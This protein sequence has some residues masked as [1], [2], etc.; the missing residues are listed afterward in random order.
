[1]KRTPLNAVG[2]AARLAA[3]AFLLAAPTALAAA[4]ASNPGSSA[5]PAPVPV[6]DVSVFS[7]IPVQHAGRVK[8]FDTFARHHLLLA[9]QSDSMPGKLASQWLAGLVLGTPGA[10][11]ER[12]FKV[13]NPE[14]LNALS[15][16]A[17]KDHFYS[18]D[19]LIAAMR[20]RAQM[21]AELHRRPR[22][23]RSPAEG[24]LVDLYTKVLTVRDLVGALSCVTPDLRVDEPTLAKDLGVAPGQG[25]SYYRLLKQRSAIS[26][27]LNQ[28]DSATDARRKALGALGRMLQAR[29]AAATGGGFTILPPKDPAGTWLSPWEVL[30]GRPLTPTQSKALDAL[31]A[32]VAAVAAGDSAGWN[33]HLTEY[34]DAVYADIAPV[35]SRSTLSL[36]VDNNRAQPFVWS[37]SF[38]ILA[39]LLLALSWLGWHAVGF[40]RVAL[41]AFGAGVLLHA[42]GIV[43]RIIIMD[44]PPV[45][46]LYESIVFVG[47]IAALSGLVLERARRTG[48]GILMGS[49]VGSV[50]H[51]VGFS[52]AAEGDT[53]GMLVA[54]LNSKFWLATHVVTIAIGYGT[55]LAAGMAGHFYLYVRAFHAD[56]PERHDE[57]ARNMRGLTLVA[58]F[59]TTL[60]TILGGIWAD[61]SWGRFWGWDPKENGALFIVLWLLV[62]V[63]GRLGG[64]LRD[65]GYA[66]WL[67]LGNVVVAV[68]WFGV[69]LLNVGLHSYGFTAGVANGLLAFGLGEVLIAGVGYGL[70]RRATARL[71]RE[72]GADR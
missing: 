35:V 27:M 56:Q 42:A 2:V 30:D 38:Y 50:L 46:T 57:V 25:V 49:V 45:A 8:P 65:L 64:Q 36:E 1:M 62:I 43:L 7:R 9:R 14:V 37:N 52:Y 39:F 55:A 16:R 70:A 13:L 12:V 26:A 19:E 68:A 31:D 24:Q 67:V 53:M 4:P 60:G 17:R 29:Q 72:P 58:I 33:Q 10:T 61:Q 6:V 48:L 34:L 15:V 23:E 63:H 22:A 59:F 18:M 11:A 40:R 71:A 69:N 47:F 20:P 44:R 5:A 3:L 21:L 28:A 32:A 66:T 41:G 54:V 51:F